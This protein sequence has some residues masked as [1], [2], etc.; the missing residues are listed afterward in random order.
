MKKLWSPFISVIICVFLMHS[1][2]AKVTF[3]P[4][5]GETPLQFGSDNSECSSILD[6]SGMPLYHL[7]DSCPAPKVFDEHC[8]YDES[9]ISECYCPS[10]FSQ[11]CSGTMKGD[12]R[13]VD[14]DSGYANCDDLWVECCDTTCPDGTFLSHPGG[15]GGFTYNDCGDKCYYPYEDC[16][17]PLPD[18]S[19]CSCGTER[20]SDGCGGSRICCKECSEDEPEEEEPSSSSSSSSSSSGGDD[21]GIYIPDNSGGYSSS[22]S[23]SSSGA[24]SCVPGG[25]LSCYGGVFSA[26]ACPNGVA[27][28]C[29]DCTG[30]THYT[31]R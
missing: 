19:G 2:N 10:I 29:K 8:P 9:Y 30:M 15:C 20:C 26:S 17:D 25:S 27:R 12:S 5:W 31:C 23:S 14:A 16:C 18:D 13:I 1:V 3:L 21:E 11:T 22:S 24:I 4:D 7:G 28:N 6:S